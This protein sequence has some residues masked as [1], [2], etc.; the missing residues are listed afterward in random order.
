MWGKSKIREEIPSPIP[1]D[2][3]DLQMHSALH[4][5]ITINLPP[6]PVLSED[7]KEQ[8]KILDAT[9]NAIEFQGPGY[10]DAYEQLCYKLGEAFQTTPGAAGKLWLGFNRNLW[11]FRNK[12]L[13]VEETGILSDEEVGLYVQRYVLRGERKLAGMKR[14][15]EAL[16]N[17]ERLPDARRERIPESVRLFVWQRD[18]GKCVRCGSREKLEYDHIIPVAEGGSDTERNIQLLCESCNRKKGASI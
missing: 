11:L 3:I 17:A 14:E 16:K 6:D 18:Q 1:K 10:R 13:L 2:G 15:S 5:A 8:V 9:I 7:L 4:L 12:L